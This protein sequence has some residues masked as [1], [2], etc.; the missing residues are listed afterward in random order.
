[1][2]KRDLYRLCEMIALTM[3]AAMSWCSVD[4]F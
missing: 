3:I 1:M 4:Y 2:T